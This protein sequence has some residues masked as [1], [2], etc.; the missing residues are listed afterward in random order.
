[1]GREGNKSCEGETRAASGLEGSRFQVG[2]GQGCTGIV[3]VVRVL[4]ERNA[5]A[6]GSAR[7]NTGA[8]A[9]GLNEKN[10]SPIVGRPYT[11]TSLSIPRQSVSTHITLSFSL[12]LTGLTPS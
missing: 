11:K 3:V 6:L 4:I 8:G 12:T 2:W 7:S 1:M 10:K 9:F 5:A